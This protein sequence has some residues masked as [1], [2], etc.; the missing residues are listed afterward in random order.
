M[1]VTGVALFLRGVAR[2][3]SPML[4]RS[5]RWVVPGTALGILPPLLLTAV[6]NVNPS[7]EIPGDRYAFLTFLLVPISFAHAIAGLE[8]ST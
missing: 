2:A 5:L 3:D 6:L 1:I 8:A 4:R 7:L